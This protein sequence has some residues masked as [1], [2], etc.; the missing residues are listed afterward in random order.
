MSVQIGG[1]QGESLCHRCAGIAVLY[2]LL[3][4]VDS[5]VFVIR[6]VQMEVDRLIPS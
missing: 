6:S 2:R 4:D 3:N 1:L 5:T